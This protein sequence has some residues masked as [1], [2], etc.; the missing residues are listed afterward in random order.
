MAAKRRSVKDP[1]HLD[2]LAAWMMGADDERTP[3]LYCK[4]DTIYSYKTPIA[5]WHEYM[6]V[7][8][9]N[10]KPDLPRTKR[11]LIANL[12]VLLT[13]LNS[14]IKQIDAAKNPETGRL[15][16]TVYDVL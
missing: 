3:W 4:G 10:N 1:S 16:P 14:D 13:I 8:V 2:I 9:F 6:E 15:E 7:A 5:Q 11:F 12:K